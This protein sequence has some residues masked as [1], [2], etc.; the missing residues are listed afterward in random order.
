MG[1]I[2]PNILISAYYLKKSL[3]YSNSAI[4]W[5]LVLLLLVCPVTEYEATSPNVDTYLA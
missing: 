1:A 2:A 4:K 5:V 3:D